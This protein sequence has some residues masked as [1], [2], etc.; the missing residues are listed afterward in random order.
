MKYSS[1]QLRDTGRSQGKRGGGTW[2]PRK[3][4]VFT[5]L[6]EGVS[7]EEGL[8]C[9]QWKGMGASRGGREEASGICDAHLCPQVVGSQFSLL[10]L[11]DLTP[12]G[13]DPQAGEPHSQG[14]GRWGL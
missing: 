14:S 6:R 12:P 5:F 4:C 7:E 2:L 3:P 13:A 9:T 1:E 10:L 8:G 11:G